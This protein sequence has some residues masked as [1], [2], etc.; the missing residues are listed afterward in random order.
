MPPEDRLEER[1]MPRHNFLTWVAALERAAQD[2]A[3][4][5]P[6]LAARGPFRLETEPCPQHGPDCA[7]VTYG[8]LRDHIGWAKADPAEVAAALLQTMLPG[9]RGG[10]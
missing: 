2:L 9:C 5:R 10:R 7:R 6:D 4:G 1:M 3:G 8:C